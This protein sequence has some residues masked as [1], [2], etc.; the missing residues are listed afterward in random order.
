[1]IKCTVHF[2]TAFDGFEV[3]IPT[4]TLVQMIQGGAVALE[5]DFAAS[6][7][8]PLVQWFS[9]PGGSPGQP[10]TPVDEDLVNNNILYLD[11]GCYLFIRALTAEQRGL[12]YQC[13]VTN[14]NNRR[15][16]THY[17]LNTD[18]ESEGL[19]TYLELGTQIGRIGSSVRFVYAGANRD[20][21]GAFVAFGV[22][23][24]STSGLNFQTANQYVVTATFGEGAEDQ[25]EV[26]FTC[27]LLGNGLGNVE[28]TGTIIVS[29][30]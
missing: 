11:G 4:V 12:Q 29:G 16:P 18:L 23:C 22:H 25:T 8:P 26:V 5:C 24:P 7:P 30:E 27:H 28:I 15:A 13:E 9:G 19:T 1:M 17:T 6:N 3:T 2:C 14:F 20:S 21:T 10:S